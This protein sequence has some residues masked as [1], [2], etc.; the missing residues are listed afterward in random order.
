MTIQIEPYTRRATEF[1]AASVFGGPHAGCTALA[2]RDHAQESPLEV[3]VAHQDLATGV[4]AKQV[5]D[6][7]C[8]QLKLAQCL[9]LHLWRFELLEDSILWR[10]AVRNASRADIVFF[11]LHGDRP[12]PSGLCHWFKHWLLLRDERPC[13]LVVSLD[14][15]ERNSDSGRNALEYLRSVAKTGGIEVFPYFDTAPVE[16]GF[17]SNAES[18]WNNSPASM[19]AGRSGLPPADKDV[20]PS[21]ELPHRRESSMADEDPIPLAAAGFSSSSCRN[22][23]LND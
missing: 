13:A 22:W 14:E 23:G 10:E 6:R 20:A 7:L 17:T 12:L 15:N 9:H 1:A 11:S 16:S 4:R 5:L 19:V 2:A 21:N 8:R 18:R 3:F